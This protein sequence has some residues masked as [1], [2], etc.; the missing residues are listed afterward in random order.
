[1]L[2]IIPKIPFKSSNLPVDSLA[3]ILEILWI[4]ALSVRILFE[5]YKC[6]KGTPES[7]GRRILLNRV[8][9]IRENKVKY[10]LGIVNFKVAHLF[11]V[12]M[13]SIN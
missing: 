3:N 2:S 12:K 9:Y 7:N 8:I 4:K 11:Q 1:M 6:L 10:L 13:S 5:M